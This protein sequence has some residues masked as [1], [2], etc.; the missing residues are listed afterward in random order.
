FGVVTSGRQ[1]FVWYENDILVD[2]QASADP[3]FLD[4]HAGSYG[5]QMST[6]AAFNPTWGRRPLLHG[7]TFAESS[8]RGVLRRAL[9]SSVGEHFYVR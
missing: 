3:Y 1:G 5:L 2:G 8:R 7:A 6:S 4:G 9:D